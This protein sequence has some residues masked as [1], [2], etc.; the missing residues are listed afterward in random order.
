[1]TVQEFVSQIKPFLQRQSTAIDN[2]VGDV[3]TLNDKIAALQATQGQL[4]P[5]DEALLA[6]IQSIAGGLA[7]KTEDLDAMTPPV[8]PPVV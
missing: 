3:K 2:V 5:E 6:D 8:A 7:T 1:M 4:T